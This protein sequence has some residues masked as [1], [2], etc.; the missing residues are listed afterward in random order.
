MLSLLKITPPS[1][2]EISEGD[3]G[4]IYN[5]G[6][7]SFSGDN[8]FEGNRD[9]NNLN[10]INN[11]GTIN[12][13]GNISLD[14]GISGDRGASNYGKVVF[15]DGANL[16]V[17]AETTTISQNDVK[18]KGATLH[19]NIRNGFFGNYEMITDYSTYALLKVNMLG[20][21]KAQ[22]IKKYPNFKNMLV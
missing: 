13:I 9:G 6:T 2:I 1:P 14:G 3:G 22:N 8:V 11:Q 10:D 16:T 19:L 5:S 4:A 21:T 15:A 20:H 12:V 7:I 18:N 17:K